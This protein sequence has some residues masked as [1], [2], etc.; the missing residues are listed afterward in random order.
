MSL[1]EILSIGDELLR[2]I[3]H[4][5]NAYRLAKR[6]AARGATLQRVTMLPDDP[7][8]VAGEI[9]AALDRAPDLIVTHGGLGPTQDDRTREAIALAA[10]TD[11]V[12]DPRAAAIVRRRY[13]E[14]AAQGVVDPHDNEARFRMADLP[15]G[16]RAFD[17]HIGTA[18]AFALDLGATTLI[19]LPGVP[20]EL[21]WIWDEQL[22][23]LLDAVLGPGG[24][25][26]R[27]FSTEIHDESGI[28]P[29]LDRIQADH[30]AVYVKS[31][32]RGFDED[33]RLRI[34]LHAIGADADAARE[35]VARAEADLRAALAAVGLELGSA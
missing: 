9:R 10:G 12:R 3:V 35:A 25:A 31:R 4:E 14:L 11:L 34:T 28:A 13:E 18:P 5:S 27:T 19:A 29:I 8:V 30:D 20:R 21:E 26:E 2:G 6:L 17:N 1:V 24:F 16:A 7:S 22:A 32:A 33:D 15:V 23:P